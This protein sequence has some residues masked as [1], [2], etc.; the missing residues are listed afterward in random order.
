ML[1][2]GPSNR[3]TPRARPSGA[4]SHLDLCSACR[5]IAW[6]PTRGAARA[7][8]EVAFVVTGGRVDQGGGAAVPIDRGPLSPI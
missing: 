7:V 5:F 3:E 6:Q 2:V 8:L 1:T 4:A